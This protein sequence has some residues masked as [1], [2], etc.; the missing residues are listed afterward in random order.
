MQITRMIIF[1]RDV[2]RLAEFYRSS[3]DL[4]FVGQASSEWAELRS[5]SC[6]LASRTEKRRWKGGWTKLVFVPS[7]WRQNAEMVDRAWK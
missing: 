6:D 5:G 7:T 3:F 1:T 2:E 4:E